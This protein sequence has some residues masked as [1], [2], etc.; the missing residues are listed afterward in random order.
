[1]CGRYS[2]SEIEKKKTKKKKELISLSKRAEFALE[3]LFSRS[4][5][6]VARTCNTR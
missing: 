5:K 1:M 4:L 2:E 3:V 6:A